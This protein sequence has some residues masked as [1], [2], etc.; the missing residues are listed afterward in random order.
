[1]QEKH[2]LRCIKESPNAGPS[3]KAASYSMLLSF[4]NNPK[5]AD[6]TQSV[7][8]T[9]TINASLAATSSADDY[10]EK[11]KPSSVPTDG[12]SER[13]RRC[14]FSQGLLLSAILDDL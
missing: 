4:I 10:L 8:T 5:P 7:E 2:L 12:N 3:F 13:A 9:R 11:S 1:M 6:K 14:E